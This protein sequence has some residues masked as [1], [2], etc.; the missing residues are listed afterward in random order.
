[1]RIL[2]TG[3]VG[4]GKTTL[5]QDYAAATGLPLLATDDALWLPEVVTAPSP[6]AAAN[7]EVARW[8]TRPGPWLIEGVRVPH[9]LARVIREAGRL[10]D[11]P[12]DPPM[13]YLT[14]ARHLETR[15]AGAMTASVLEAARHCERRLNVP[16]LWTTYTPSLLP[17]LLEI[18][19]CDRSS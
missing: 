3:G 13:V 16:V 10:G 1:M 6:W 2:I 14:Q 19:R 7:A 5:A 8:I 15:Q 9:A 17:K 18:T 12:F 4:T 11:L